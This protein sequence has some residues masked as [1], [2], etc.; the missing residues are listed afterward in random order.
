MAAA[1]SLDALKADVK[2]GTIDTILCCFPDL[3]S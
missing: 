2:N 3:V 1:Y